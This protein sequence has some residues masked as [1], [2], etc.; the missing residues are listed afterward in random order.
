MEG[1]ILS[2]GK[3]GET[4]VI[5]NVSGE[6]FVFSCEGW[7]SDNPPRGG[8]SVDFIVEGNRA[9]NIYATNPVELG[10]KIN[11]WLLKIRKSEFGENVVDFFSGGNQNKM[12][13][14]VS[15]LFLVS[16]C[17]P[18]ISIPMMG[19]F[20][21]SDSDSGMLLLLLM[22]VSGLLFYG[23]ARKFYLRLSVVVFTIVL[24]SAYY[25]FFRIFSRAGTWVNI[26]GGAAVN[27]FQDIFYFLKI[28]MFSNILILLPLFYFSFTKKY[29]ERENKFASPAE[30]LARVFGKR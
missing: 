15:I 14:Y 2:V 3:E 10:D 23:G 4:G 16:L 13:F 30:T 5:R 24:I 17:L 1:I 6:R 20:S 12:G 27:D 28:G 11:Y 29:M 21:M 18:M 26:A 9:S 7:M 22:V 19:T 25:D 8:M